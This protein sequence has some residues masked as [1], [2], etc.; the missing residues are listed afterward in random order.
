MDLII[1]VIIFSVTIGGTYLSLY[2]LEVFYEMITPEIDIVI[3]HQM[4]ITLAGDDVEKIYT[5]LKAVDEN[6]LSDRRIVGFG[7]RLCQKIDQQREII[8]VKEVEARKK[9]MKILMDQYE[10]SLITEVDSKSP[11]LITSNEDDSK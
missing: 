7:K 2:L 8:K 6:Q 1:I 11:D 5:L 10:E 3:R 9:A 4:S